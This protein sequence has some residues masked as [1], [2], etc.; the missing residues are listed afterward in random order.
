VDV[1]F[2]GPPGA[3]K[4]TQAKRLEHRE[5]LVQI[6]TGDLL[7]RHRQDG[8]PLGM[9]AQAYMDRGELVPDAL[10]IQMMS[11]E[12]DKAT[13]GV[14]LDGFPRTEA[15]AHALDLLLEAMRRQP[16][17]AVLFEI[18]MKL[19]EERLMGRWTNPRTGRVYHEKF[20]PPLV[21]RVDDDDGGELVQ[22]VDDR[23]DTIR[24]RLRIYKEQTKPLVAYYE[25]QARLRRIDATRPVDVVSD[26]INRVLHP[27]VVA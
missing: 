24:K 15:Q 2:I 14:L 16:A 9:T 7:R 4:G 23:P 27:G 22:R 11:G 8:S 25:A 19:L 3:G 18:P 26:D 10:I 1:V 12:I 5:G 6:S 17:V 21:T 13:C 20:A